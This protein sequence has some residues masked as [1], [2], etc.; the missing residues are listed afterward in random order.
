[1]KKQ[2]ENSRQDPPVQLSV[3]ELQSNR[4]KSK[5][6]NPRKKKTLRLQTSKPPASSIKLKPSKIR[7]HF[8]W[9]LTLTI[10]CFFTIGP[11]WALYKVFKLRRMIERNELD[12]AASLSY[13][14]SAV[15]VISTI[16]GVFVWVSILFC[17]VGL[18]L[19][20]VLLSHKFI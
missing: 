11:C 3:K 2:N 18:I 9:A 1:M 16:I 4:F 19:T 15:L 12:A 14:I 20:G 10:F 5:S 7:T 13:K 6:Q 17:S 8:I